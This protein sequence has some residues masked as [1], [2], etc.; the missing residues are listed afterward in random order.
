[1]STSKIAAL[2]A[3]LRGMTAASEWDPKKVR[4]AL[5]KWR[6][7]AAVPEKE[8]IAMTEA[9]ETDRIKSLDTSVKS[10]EIVKFLDEAIT[11][12]NRASL[13]LH[14]VQRRIGK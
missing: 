13:A 4:T 7:H 12:F 1:M 10:K 3:D 8:L 14:H 6:K 5:A 9:F 2:T 11:N